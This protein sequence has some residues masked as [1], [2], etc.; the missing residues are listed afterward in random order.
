MSD[1][2]KVEP[3]KEQI[4]IEEIQALLRKYRSELVRNVELRLKGAKKN[5]TP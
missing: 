2:P 3:S 1:A 4:W 5:A